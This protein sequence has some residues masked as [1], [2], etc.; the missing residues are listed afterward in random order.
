TVS[1]RSLRN[2]STTVI[3]SQS[4][5]VALLTAANTVASDTVRTFQF[6]LAI[7][8]A[9]SLLAGDVLQL[10][11]TQNRVGGS[12]SFPQYRNMRVYSSDNGVTSLAALTS[13][14]VIN[15]DTVTIYDDTY[16][17]G[18]SITTLNPGQNYYVRA[19]VTDPFGAYDV[20][21]TRLTILG[22]EGE[23][24]VN[25][26]VMSAVNATSSTLTVEFPYVTAGDAV[27]GNWQF[28]V[29]AV[30]GYE[31]KVFNVLN[32][33][34]PL[35]QPAFL[36]MVKSMQVVSDP[37]NG[38][39]NPKAIPGA[40]VEYTI[41]VTNTGEGSTDTDTITLL[42][43]LADGTDLMVGTDSAV[44]PVILTDGTPT[45]TLTLSFESLTSTT[46]SVEFSNNNGATFDYQPT[47]D[48]EGFDPLITDI[49]IRPTGAMPGT[50]ADGSPAFSIIYKVKVN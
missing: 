32:Q 40:I 30:E 18:N 48:A 4:Q 37:L 12:A 21:D 33:T 3:A 2:G 39:N 1:L 47:P 43:A 27:S 13:N 15:V 6:D 19:E 17:D 23:V 14:T 25:N 41:T 5:T 50:G 34:V 7:S 29:R 9:Q 44:S 36:T 20:T 28:S 45:S 42:D 49:R 22:P 38:S 11:V 35:L 24:P 46:D 10:A 16:P 31:G 26:A 8:N